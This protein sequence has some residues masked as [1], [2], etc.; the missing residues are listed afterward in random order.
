MPPHHQITAKHRIASVGLPEGLTLI[1]IIISHHTAT[2][3]SPWGT[4]FPIPFA[5]TPTKNWPPPIPYLASL[6]FPGRSAHYLAFPCPALPYPAL[7]CSP[8]PSLSCPT[9]F[10]FSLS[11]PC[12]TSLYL[13]LPYHF[14]LSPAPPLLSLPSPTLSYPSKLSLLYLVLPSYPSPTLPLLTLPCPSSPYRPLLCSPFPYLSPP[15][16]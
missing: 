16:T 7:P 4:N 8:L 11:L 15:L 13:P 5:G 6:L 10:L 3:C 2:F 9:L 12:P 1:V 14:L